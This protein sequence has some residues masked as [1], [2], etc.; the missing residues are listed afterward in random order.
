V[1]LR[2]RM[3]KGLQGS[4]AYTWSHA[5]DTSLGAGGDS[6]SV[7]YSGDPTSYDGV[8]AHDKGSSNN[9]Q[10][11][12]LVGSFV[13]QPR[14]TKRTDKFSRYV[15]NNWQVSTV[16]TIASAYPSRATIS[17]G[18][19]IRPNNQTLEWTG[20]INGYGGSYRVPF[21]PVNPLRIDR[22][23]RAD[24]R[25]SKLLPL[26][27]RM[28]LYLNFEAFNIANT[29]YNTS[30]NQTA[31]TANNGVLTPNSGLG[32]GI[33]SGGFPDGTNARRLQLGGRLVF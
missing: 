30:V 13:A 6:A 20:S 9:D 3:A 27:E 28:K 22:I 11:H 25:L 23:C 32:V 17:V 7:F 12:R 2:K 14:F 21:W 10:R 18:S 19:A 4:L 8:Y 1:Q 33:A 16:V 24:A 5:I 31:Y 26:T 29:Q 15:V